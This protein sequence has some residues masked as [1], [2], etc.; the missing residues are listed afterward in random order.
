M[1]GNHASHL[2]RGPHSPA[3]HPQCLQHSGGGDSGPRRGGGTRRTASAQP[4]APPAVP[5]PAPSLPL[6]SLCAIAHHVLSRCR[7]SRKMERA[8]ALLN[9]TAHI[10]LWLRAP[11]EGRAA[12]LPQAALTTATLLLAVA[13]V[14]GEAYRRHRLFLV[15][16]LRFILQWQTYTMVRRRIDALQHHWL[17]QANALHCSGA[18]LP[19]SPCRCTALPAAASLSASNAPPSAAV[20]P[21][22]AVA[23]G[24]AA[25]PAGHAARCRGPHTGHT[26]SRP[27]GADAGV[28]AAAARRG[29]H[30]HRCRLSIQDRCIHLPDRGAVA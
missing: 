27:G 26:A 7:M 15:P 10:V 8:A 14:R 23:A 29:A 16:L 5:H 19:R 28:C 6:R 2:Y 12:S 11:P 4:G 18:C 25:R 20:H 3:N 22:P 17:L 1:R 21:G 13:S 24:T 9:C 30:P